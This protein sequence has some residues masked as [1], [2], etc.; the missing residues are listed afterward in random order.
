MPR[1]ERVPW[2]WLSPIFALALLQLFALAAAADGEAIEI[3]PPS[4]VAA[5]GGS[6]QFVAT[7]RDA[8][9]A[10][11]AGRPINFALGGA[12]CRVA[13]DAATDAAGQAHLTVTATS[14]NGCNGLVPAEGTFT[15]TASLAT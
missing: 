5:V 4:A 8:A 9:G 11:I 14:S 2:H 10:P 6:L 1:L 3:S 12:A 7:A 13:G 15:V